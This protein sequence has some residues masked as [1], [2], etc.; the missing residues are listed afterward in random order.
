[1]KQELLLATGLGIGSM[2]G[3]TACSS[4]ETTITLTRVTATSSTTADEV[5]TSCNVVA[6]RP[7]VTAPRT[8]NVEE[9]AKRLGR[10]P[11]AAR[12]FAVV[13]G[14]TCSE[15]LNLVTI[16]STSV[17]VKVTGQV[18]PCLAIGGIVDQTINSETKDVLAVCF[19]ATPHLI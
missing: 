17:K 16:H 9:I 1:M 11:Q 18:E 3:A 19:D 2:L 8:I 12:A 14:V 7:F 13:G 10:N 15:N 6:D 5:F 4:G